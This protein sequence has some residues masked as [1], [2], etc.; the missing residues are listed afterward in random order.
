MYRVKVGI[1]WK[2]NG[3]EKRA[4]PGDLVDLPPATAEWML[5]DELIEQSEPKKAPARKKVASGS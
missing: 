3:S 5:A 4:E 2:V 1:N